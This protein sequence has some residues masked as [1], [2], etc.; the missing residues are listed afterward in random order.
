MKSGDKSGIEFNVLSCATKTLDSVDKWKFWW[1]RRFFCWFCSQWSTSKRINLEWQF[2]L[3]NNWGSFIKSHK[4]S[5]STRCTWRVDWQSNYLYGDYCDRRNLICILGEGG[6]L[7]MKPLTTHWHY[8][9]GF[10]CNEY[11]FCKEKLFWLRIKYLWQGSCFVKYGN[12]HAKMFGITLRGYFWHNA[13]KNTIEVFE[14]VILSSCLKSWKFWI[15]VIGDRIII[16]L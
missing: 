12:V 5:K 2:F 7:L 13:V 16:H 10:Y 1:S 9:R 3:S 4:G 6:C 11:V 14:M 8:R 15:T